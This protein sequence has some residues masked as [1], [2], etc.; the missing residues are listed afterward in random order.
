M[1]IKHWFYT[2]P[3]RLRSLF[4]RARVEQELD[5]E[6]RYHIARQIEE[7]MSKG[8]TPEEARY[9][10]L[11]AIGGLEQRKEE[12]REMRR[13]NLIENTLQDL[14]YASRLLR[15]NPGFTLVAVLSLA[16][17]IGAN[18]AIFQLLNVVRLRSLPIANPQELVETV[19]AGGNRG[20]GVS[21]G[22]NSELTNPLW[23]QIREHQQA[24]SGVFAWG[25]AIFT[26]GEGIETQR[27]NGLWVSGDYFPVLGINP[28]RGR[29]FTSADD[30]RGCGLGGAIISH[31]FWQSHFGG[32]DSVV[33]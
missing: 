1:R 3:L 2:I 20:H 21:D 15:R 29:L 11:R 8:K 4:R 6:L 14:R 5:E 19:I 31:S 22:F 13:L 9:A 17:G 30:S 33:G 25:D 27:V 24:F 18:T 23:E 12:C 16:L 32:D 7:H 10:A 28:V 26:V